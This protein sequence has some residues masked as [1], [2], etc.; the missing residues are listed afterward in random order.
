MMPTKR[1]RLPRGRKGAVSMDSLTIPQLLCFMGGWQPPTN[2]FDRRYG[3]WDTWKEFMADWVAVREEC[4][5]SE[6]FQRSGP[7]FAEQVYK[8]F[9]AKGPPANATSDDVRAAFVAA[10]DEAAAELLADVELGN[11]R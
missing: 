3:G 9:G 8:T 2:D 11:G 7:N 6:P 1:K 10:E 5:A 4:L